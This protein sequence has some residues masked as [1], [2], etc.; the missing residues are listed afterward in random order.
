MKVKK[1]EK[2]IYFNVKIQLRFSWGRVRTVWSAYSVDINITN[3]FFCK[4]H[5]V[6]FFLFPC[7]SACDIVV[8]ATFRPRNSVPFKE[9]WTFLVSEGVL[10]LAY[11]MPNNDPLLSDST[12][13]CDNR[14]Y[15]SNVDLITSFGNSG[16]KFEKNIQSPKSGRVQGCCSLILGGCEV[17]GELYATSLFGWYPLS[18]QLRC[19]PEIGTYGWGTYG[20]PTYWFC[21]CGKNWFGIVY[22]L[23]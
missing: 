14:E 18:C 15:R 10:N 6:I 9:S 12:F 21:F 23:P 13:K 7:M 8:N 19:P 22:P 16:G 1:R 4:I 3:F 2:E 5:F 17:E 11:P 20:L